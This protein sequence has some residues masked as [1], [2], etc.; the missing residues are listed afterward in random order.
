MPDT[1]SVCI[2]IWVY[3]S[4]SLWIRWTPF[5]FIIFIGQLRH[6]TLFPVFIGSSCPRPLS[7]WLGSRIKFHQTILYFTEAL[8]YIYIFMKRMYPPKLLSCACCWKSFWLCLLTC[9]SYYYYFISKFTFFFLLLTRTCTQNYIDKKNPSVFIYGWNFST[10]RN[11]F[12]KWEFCLS[13]FLS[14]SLLKK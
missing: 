14:L 3:L 5:L 4:I 10:S 9:Q 13:K 7:S 12:F 6:V 11:F 8:L 2:C 1:R